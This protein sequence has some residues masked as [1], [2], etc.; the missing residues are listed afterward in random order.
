MTTKQ[1]KRLN[2]LN[3]KL[4]PLLPNQK[5][6]LSEDEAIVLLLRRGA[7]KGRHPAVGGSQP[8]LREGINLRGTQKGT[9]AQRG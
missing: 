2:E 8:P 1:Q 7:D 3:D 9:S 6:Q 4:Q 5:Q